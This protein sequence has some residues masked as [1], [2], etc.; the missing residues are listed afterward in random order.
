EHWRHQSR[1]Y[2]TR[3]YWIGWNIHHALYRQWHCDHGSNL[4]SQVKTGNLTHDGTCSASEGTYQAVSNAAGTTQAQANTAAIT[5]YRNCL[6][7]ALANNC[8]SDTFRSALRS[9]GA[10]GV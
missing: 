1:Q 6:T 3:R 7:S 9:L 4:V 8:G 10:G 5:H 2:C